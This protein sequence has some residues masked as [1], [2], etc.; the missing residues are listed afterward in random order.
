MAAAVGIAVARRLPGAFRVPSVTGAAVLALLAGTVFAHLLPQLPGAAAACAVLALAVPALFVRR[1]PPALACLALGFGWCALRAD[2]ALDARLP[3]A[4]E[5]RDIRVTGHVLDLPETRPR[6]SRFDFRVDGAQLDGRPLAF[7]GHVRLNWYDAVPALPPCSHWALT[8]RLKR[9]RGLVNPGGFD[10]E[11]Y[12]VQRGI[13]AVGY[14]RDDVRNRASAAADAVCVDRLRLAISD[15]IAAGVPAGPV[16]AVLQALAVG[17]QRALDEHDWQVLRATGIS[18]LI[19]I[20]G[21][22]VGLFAAFGALLARLLWKNFAR[23]TLRLPGP[24]IEAPAALAFACAY[25]M[26]AGLGVPTVRTLLMIATALLA[27]YSRRGQSLPHALALAA[28]TILL[29]DPLALLAAGFWLSFAGVAALLMILSPGLG[30]TRWWR[31]LPRAQLALSVALL[32][33]TVWFFGQA[34]LPGPLANLI[35]VPWVSFVVVPLTV[36][37]GLL[38]PLAPLLGTP[39]L[40]LAWLALTP[41]WWM[42]E[43]LAALPL[44]QQYFPQSP[45]WALPV[46]LIGVAWCLAPRGVPA[47]VLGLA[48]LLPLLFPSRHPLAKGDFDLLVLDVGQ[49]L[50]VLVRT[51]GHTLLYDT[52]A[53]YPSG[54]DLGEAVVVPTLRSLGVDRLDRLIVS[55]GDND[56]AGGARAVTLALHPADV[57]SGEP[58]RL[59]IGARPCRAGEHWIWDQ[60]G[61]RLIS[62]QPGRPAHDNDRSCVLVISGRHG[63]ALLPGDAS[64]RVEPALARALGPVTR[65]LVL[66]VPHHGSASSSSA[67][68]LDAVAPDRALVSAGYR[69]RFGHPR[70]EVVARYAAR[71]IALFGTAPSGSLGMRLDAAAAAPERGRVLRR[72]WWRER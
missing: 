31:E 55:H 11:R 12:A 57:E 42:L 24:L 59:A 30:E 41:L 39:L 47:R 17:D 68:F 13:V 4:L 35:A 21:L 51:A 70:P 72:A 48:L 63:S 43:R 54:F 40:K 32:P 64:E 46:A 6:S 69:N 18:H 52:G 27:R 67:G 3:V 1:V 2:F 45:A 33:L 53:R 7:G 58:E 44:A 65:P 16:A 29:W 60:V 10:F 61:F 50:S 14:V 22:H 62:P 36:T 38:L 20:S 15:A 26:L 71:G 23:C 49:G 25:G 66:V 28:L 5:G 56:H 8:V 19:A 37:A 34:S 9:P